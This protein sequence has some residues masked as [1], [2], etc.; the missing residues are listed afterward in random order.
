[1]LGRAARDAED[2]IK[3]LGKKVN[4]EKLSADFKYDGERT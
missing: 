3:V 2:V 4:H 1:M